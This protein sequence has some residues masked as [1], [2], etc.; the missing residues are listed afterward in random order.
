MILAKKIGEMHKPNKYYL[1]DVPEAVLR[2]AIIHLTTTRYRPILSKVVDAQKAST[3]S[4]VRRP[5]SL[6]SFASTQLLSS[7]ITSLVFP[8]QTVKEGRDE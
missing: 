6:S 8:Q 7:W 2:E 1:E 3:G 5:I 4:I